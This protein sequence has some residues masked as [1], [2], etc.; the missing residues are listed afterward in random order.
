MN[1]VDYFKSVLAAAAE[2]G[3]I[4]VIELLLQHGAQLKDS[5]AIVL[6]A[7]EGQ[8]DM[9]RFLLKKG[10]DINEIGVEDKIDERET[11]EMG[12][13]LHKAIVG[14]HEGVVRLLLDEGA[15][16][17]SKDIQERTPLA[18]ARQRGKR[19]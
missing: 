16:T 14:G 17:N 13:A 11:A 6:A 3:H 9:I 5:G 7:E 2:S 19:R 1:R 15:D 10:A 12:T 4:E 8:V 18:L